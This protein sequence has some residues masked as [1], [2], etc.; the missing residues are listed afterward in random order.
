MPRSQIRRP[1]SQS[2]AFVARVDRVF[3]M[4]DRIL[5]TTAVGEAER[6]TGFAGRKTITYDALL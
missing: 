4:S 6:K 5:D 2:I 3:V 1:P